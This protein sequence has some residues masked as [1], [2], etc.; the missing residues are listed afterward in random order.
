VWCRGAADPGNARDANA[1]TDDIA[2]A[3]TD[4][5][6]ASL[7][8]EDVIFMFA[9]SSSPPLSQRV[10]AQSTATKETKGVLSVKRLL[11]AD[12]CFAK[13]KDT[14][15]LPSCILNL[16]LPPPPA[17]AEAFAGAGCMRI[18]GTC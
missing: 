18:V 14:S 11:Q 7:N 9:T 16:Q 6:P 15:M 3:D 12:I 4:K 1:E 8:R 5:F 10:K 13:F 17:A 2:D